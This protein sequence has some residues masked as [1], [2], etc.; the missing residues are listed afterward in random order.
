MPANMPESRRSKTSYKKEIRK[1]LSDPFLRSALER[2]SDACREGRSSAY[3]GLDF[4]GMR[5]DLSATKEALPAS[6]EA[7]F[8]EFKKNAE[9][10]GARVHFAKDAQ[11]A[12]DLISAIAKLSHAKWIVKSKSMTCE[13]IFLNRR[14]EGDG[15]K[16]T[17]TDLGEWI[18]QLRRERPSH[19]VMPAIHLSRGQVS[20]LFK[21]EIGKEADPE[22]IPKMV[23]MAR[24]ALRPAFLNADMG[25]TGANFAVADSGALG[26]VTN[27]GNMRLTTTFPRVH[28]ALVG[29][30]K[31]LP[32]MGSALKALDLLTRNATGQAIT[33]YVTWIK[34]AVECGAA[35]FGGPKETHILFLD[36]GRL[37]LA[38]D[39]VFSKS[40]KC[41]RCGA[42]ANV[43][44]IYSKVGGHKYGHV[45]I[46]AIG[47]ILTLFY[48]G[49]GEAS[50]IVKNCLNCGACAQ[51]C[52][53]AIDLPWLIKKSG[54][55]V[56][57]AQGR[58]PVK[59]IGMSLAMRNRRLFH[60]LLRAA[61]I[62]GKPFDNGDGLIRH[63][64]DFVERRHGFRRLPAIAAIPFRKRWEK[65]A[66]HPDPPLHSAA[67]FCGCAVD[68]IYPGQG[69]AMLKL[70]KRHGVQ[71]DF[72]MDQTCCGLP[73][74]AA[75]DRHGGKEF[76]RVNIEAFSHSD[77]RPIVTL[78]AS[79]G[80]HMKNHYKKMFTP[81]SAMFKKAEAFS[82]RI[83]DFSSF[84]VN[85]LKASPSEFRRSGQ[86]AA[87]HSPC[88]LCRGLNVEKEPRALIEI[89]GFD[90]VPSKD[91]DVCC[92]FGGSYSVDFPEISAEILKK[93]LDH[94][95]K[96]KARV[97]L[98]DCPGCV[99]QLRGGM[100]KRKG[101]MAVM[102][103]AEAL[104]ENMI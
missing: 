93:K 30:D 1:A 103:M 10:A 82:D 46:G 40:L 3:E 18:I 74:F 63:L 56:I 101:G 34:G 87:Y 70:F 80:S 53:V 26:I 54:E 79:C 19:M 68:F 15:F 27:E 67:F 24:Q 44:P 81:G 49:H 89:G 55:A 102:H 57:L 25:I 47:L 95:Q 97:L 6:F 78:C 31:L 11:E 5:D 39:P 75:S 12:N 61:H 90:Y 14:L 86:R 16:V 33:S 7:L 91:E 21:Q 96:S 28:V 62:A 42:C 35:P 84:M 73:A 69:E 99:M 94:V 58:A 59:N 104:A 23:E 98:T 9:K 71:I 60:L 41:I 17:E 100:D 37:A 76:A 22:D 77:F 36:N 66:P 88:H 65:I 43:C 83:I 4:Q 29:M 51:V 8:Q 2:F 85:V 20:R 32:D 50:D 64:P 48:H 38:A 45:Y 13:E 72:P 92:G 52:P